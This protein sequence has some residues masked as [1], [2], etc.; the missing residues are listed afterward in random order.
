MKYIVTGG[1]GFIGSDVCRRLVRDGHEVLNIDSLEYSGT[2]ESVSSI[3]GEC[4]YLFAKGNICNAKLM[5]QY[6]FGYKPDA[7]IHLAAETHVDRS[8]TDP[9]VFIKTNVLGTATLLDV[10]RKY[11]NT[12]EDGSSFRFHHVSTDEVYG[13]L[14]KEE[15][16]SEN[17]PYDPSSPYSAS[18]AGS[19]HLTMAYYKTYRLPVTISNTCNNYGPYQFPE[20]FI[21]LTIINLLN[22]NKIRIYGDGKQIRDWIHVSDHTDGIIK[23]LHSGKVGNK[24]NIGNSC[25]LANIEV[26]D[27]IC[28]EMA[29]L[30]GKSERSYKKLKTY[31]ED[32]PGHD[33]RY[34][35]SPVKMK[36]KLGWVGKVSFRDGIRDTI[37]WY[38]DNRD[39][40]EPIYENKRLGVIK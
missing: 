40:W 30:T 19:D 24:Y 32:R 22:G 3:S 25:E 10:A 14:G 5:E 27:I 18:K 11:H 9:F 6:I 7:I 23:I 12:L 39:W 26:V 31:V 29:K 4:N 35:I 28:E 38:I 1:C 2:L 36:Y 34:G 8:I 20:K 21:P 33:F 15:L 16:F 17:T 37:K 13:S